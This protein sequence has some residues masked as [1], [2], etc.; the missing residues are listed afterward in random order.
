MNRLRLLSGVFFL[1]II[2]NISTYAQTKEQ[3]N[4]I[5]SD[6]PELQAFHSI[7]Y[8]LWHKAYP[9]KDFVT[10]KGFIPQIK[11]NME[12]MNSAKLPGILREK[13]DLWK[14]ELAKFNE[15]AEFYYKAC[16]ENNEESILLA[17]EKFHSAYEVMNRVVKPFVKEMESFHKTLYMIYHKMYP[18]KK[19]D[20]ILNVMDTL[21]AQAD[22]ITKH[23]ED[24]LTKR[25]KD[26]T[27]KYYATAKN[28]HDETIALKIALKS[29]DE[30]NIDDAIEKMHTSYKKLE[31][32]FE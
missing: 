13:E 21:I 27:P 12:K 15:V 16:F 26:K 2:A 30:K 23:P 14:T 18:E 3:A 5:S 17:V 19:Y 9:A 25:L 32:L 31:S 10:I 28:L 11:A 8:P 7:I 22:A 29:N 6:I 1:A 24:R 4:E 20:E